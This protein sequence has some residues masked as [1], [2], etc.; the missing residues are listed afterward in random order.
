LVSWFV[1]TYKSI[2]APDHRLVDG[3]LLDQQKT[4]NLHK[5]T[6]LSSWIR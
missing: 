6:E 2:F 4:G 1:S 5:P 3:L